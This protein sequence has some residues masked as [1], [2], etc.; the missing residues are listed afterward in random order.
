MYVDRSEIDFGR[1]MGNALLLI[2]TNTLLALLLLSLLSVT[3]SDAIDFPQAWLWSMV[4][5]ASGNAVIRVLLIVLQMQKRPFAYGILQASLNVFNLLL[6]LFLVV[7]LEKTWKGAILSDI[8]TYALFGLVSLFILS[9][10]FRLNYAP[11]KVYIK[12]LLAFNMPI[13][14]HLIGKSI[15]IMSDKLFISYYLGLNETG[16]Y[17]AGY[18]VGLVVFVL[19]NAFQ[20]AFTPEMYEKLKEGSLESKAYLVRV[21][22]KYSLSIVSIALAIGFLAPYI[23]DVFLG[24]EYSE[25]WV[26]I[27]WIS[28]G[29][30]L[31][32]IY[33]PLS[34]LISYSKKTYLLMGITIGAAL[35][36]IGL[37]IYLIQKNGSLGAAQA[38][39]ITFALV[40]MA[41]FYFANRVV[42][43]PWL[44][45]K[46]GR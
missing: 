42:P 40:A 32:G 28:L 3:I 7:Y 16:M 21:I 39:L 29:F 18:Q 14:V 22:Y 45:K 30:A 43:M 11:H 34:T 20:S 6:I 44:N 19:S 17:S 38:T 26:Y 13:A 31:N 33:M 27:F 41:T 4:I 25:A 24:D 12:D 9:R 1:Y 8:T 46:L 23:V 35:V 36:N 5:F 2:L 37:N 10:K 15:L